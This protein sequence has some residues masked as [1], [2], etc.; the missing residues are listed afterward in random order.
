MQ[1]VLI[2]TD[3]NEYG[4]VDFRTLQQWAAD[5]RLTRTSKLRDLESGSEIVAGSLPDLFPHPI[6]VSTPA[7]AP[8]PA[9]PDWSQPPSPYTRPTAAL[10]DSFPW[11]V[12]IYSALGLLLFFVLQGIGI[13]FAGFA[14]YY[15]VLLKIDGSK[16]A[17]LALGVSVLSLAA[18][19]IGFYFRS[20]GGG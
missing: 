1:Y 3:G 18:I 15:A 10:R 8:A 16:W 4:P 19:L 6:P 9:Q 14:V 12:V 5:D 2:G 20:T 11:R 13:V 17:P 7:P